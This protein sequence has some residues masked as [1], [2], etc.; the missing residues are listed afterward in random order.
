[1]TNYNGGSTAPLAVN[2]TV[3]TDSPKVELGKSKAIA[4]A[5]ATVAVAFLGALG[6]AVAD[7]VVTTGEWITIATA[8]IIATGLVGGATY[9]VPTTVTR[10]R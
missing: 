9:V 8:T 10:K 3:S 5:V 2:E 6:V 4:A 7:E 1:M